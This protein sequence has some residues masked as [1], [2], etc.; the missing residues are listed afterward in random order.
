[1][2]RFE[3][4]DPPSFRYR[5]GS[6]SRVSYF[7][8]DDAGQYAYYPGHPMKPFRIR[9]AHE[10]ITT[11]GVH[12]KMQVYRAKRATAM[13]M[14]QFHTDDY[15]D[16]L[17]RITPDNIRQFPSAHAEFGIWEDNPVFE[18]LYEFC[19]ISAGGSME[20]AAHLNHGKCDIAIN[21]AGGLHHAKK[22]MA[23]GF[24]YINDIV[25][26]ILELLRFHQR[27]LY[28]DIDVHH[29]D[30]VEEAFL[31][32]DRVMTV[33]FHRFGDFFPGTGDIRDIGVNRGRYHAVNVPLRD[34]IDDASYK[35]I[36]Q[37]IICGIM[38]HFRPEAI[39]MQCGSDSLS[40]DRL[41]SFNLSMEGHANCVS[42]VKTFGIPMLVLGGGGYTVRNVARAWANE[43]AVLA[44]EELSP[45]IPYNTFYEHFAPDYMLE[46]KPSN[47]DNLNTYEYLEGLKVEILENLREID[48]A[49]SVQMQDVPLTP[50]GV[51]DP[52]EW[53][54]E[55]EE[56]RTWINKSQPTIAN[57]ITPSMHEFL[58]GLIPKRQAHNEPI[59]RQ[60]KLR[61]MPSTQDKMRQGI[62]M[63]SLQTCRNKLYGSPAGNARKQTV[64]ESR[65]SQLEDLVKL[66]ESQIERNDNTRMELSTSEFDLP[67]PLPIPVKANA[68]LAKDFFAKLSHEV[69]GIR[70]VL[71]DSNEGNSSF[72]S[73]EP[74]GK[75]GPS[76]TSILFGYQPSI[77]DDELLAP[78]AE[79][80]REILLDIYHDRVDCLFK[81]T[82]W[83]AAETAIHRKYGPDKQY[84]PSPVIHAVERAVY[85]MAICTMTESECDAM[86]SESKSSLIYRH[87]RSVE[88]ALARSEFF[89][90]PDKLA[91]QSF[92]LYLMGLRVC[93]QY[94]M[95]WTLLALAI[96]S[97][98]A[99][100]LPI[101]GTETGQEKEVCEHRSV[102]DDLKMR[103]WYCIGMLDSQTSIDRGT[104]PMMTLRD[105][106]MKPLIINHEAGKYAQPSKRQEL[107]WD[108]A[109]SHVI[110]E[111]TICSRRLMEFPPDVA[112]SW[113]SWPKKLQVISEFETYIRQ[114]CS[115]LE[116]CPHQLQRFI[117]FTAEDIVLNM[118]LL[119]RRPPYP[120]KNSPFPPWDKFDVLKVTT[121]I[122]ERTLWKA[123]DSAFAPWAWLSKTWLKWQVLA[124]LL[125]ELCTPRYGELGDRAYRVAK[126]GFDYCSS[127]MAESD[128]AT[129][130]KPL[131]KLMARVNKVRAGML[132]EQR[133]SSLSTVTGIDTP[134]HIPVE[135]NSHLILP[136][137]VSGS[138]GFPYNDNNTNSTEAF[139]TTDKS[140]QAAS[141]M[142]GNIS[143]DASWLNWNDFLSEM[144]D[145]WT[146]DLNT[147]YYNSVDSSTL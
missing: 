52:L 88:V 144:G 128:L 72:M 50:L 16:F 47:M 97:G 56:T 95:S 68:M 140:A 61:R 107:S 79:N 19:S 10:L 114:Y 78:P 119:L 9:L 100:G 101:T 39:V 111:A 8:D 108:M 123:S 62:P 91:L 126:R 29:G 66:L 112:G 36:F 32:T 40:G 54:L 46:V 142:N 85:F 118:H 11:Y 22:S 70:E 30:G 82:Y 24:C 124:V 64:L 89:T 125:A 34:G 98:N 120:S 96:R 63:F 18:G 53:Q 135:S 80:V 73:P 12:R 3:P 129:V 131:E 137:G 67:N 20:G 90:N 75:T 17:R 134:G 84:S 143:I 109:F 33:S 130:L 77:S 65:V 81:A 4:V 145:V 49:P 83:P 48:F 102:G 13:E 133:S 141:Y 122:M 99:L 15:V 115:Q 28:I 1:M 105:F 86:L 6:K 92:V 93:S 21:W 147:E 103:L 43:T 35:S 42:F 59:S 104:R 38:K 37:P 106:E 51:F 127:L 25:L 5:P 26:G 2:D 121:E 7:Y 58:K 60:T 23:N 138:T 69:A 117:Q 116:G 87:Q 132:S 27:V 55:N 136:S 146:A 45:V 113:E 57:Y 139:S 44:E 76:S 110:H 71:D 31:T 14:T 74:L 94:A 41:G